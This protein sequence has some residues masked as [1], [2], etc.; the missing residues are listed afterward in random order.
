MYDSFNN[1][2]RLGASCLGKKGGI[3]GVSEERCEERL[4]LR[5]IFHC[6]HPLLEIGDHLLIYHLCM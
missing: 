6:C 1:R 5:M 3:A 4:L 2:V